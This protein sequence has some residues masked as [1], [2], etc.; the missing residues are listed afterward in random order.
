MCVYKVVVDLMLAGASQWRLWENM[1]PP[2]LIV[3]RHFFSVAILGPPSDKSTVFNVSRSRLA[4]PLKRLKR[5]LQGL[6]K[7]VRQRMAGNR[8]ACWT[9]G[10]KAFHGGKN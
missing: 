1:V 8:G 9:D 3:D 10:M 5:A 7:P 2:C 4:V 6:D